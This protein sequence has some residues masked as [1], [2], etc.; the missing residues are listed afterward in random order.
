MT[1]QRHLISFYTLKRL[2]LKNYKYYLVH[3]F[4]PSLSVSLL[5]VSFPSLFVGSSLI[6][7]DLHLLVC[8]LLD[9]SSAKSVQ[10]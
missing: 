7:K 1:F 9:Q 4:F 10:A 5:P 3:N 8:L 2:L 6:R